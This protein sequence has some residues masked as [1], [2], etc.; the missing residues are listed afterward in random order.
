M[1]NLTLLCVAVVAVVAIASFAQANTSGPFTTS[2]PIGYTLTDWSSSLSFPKFNSALGTLTEVDLTFNAG[3]ETTLTVT[4]S[5]D[6][7]S[8][9][10]AN[11]NVQL[12]VE[13]PGSYFSPPQVNFLSPAYYYTLA[14]GGSTTSGLLTSTGSGTEDDTLPA[15]LAEFNGPGTIGLPASTFTQ[16]YVANTGGN[17]AAGQVTDAELTGTVTYQ[18][19]P[20][21]TPEPSTLLLLGMGAIGLLG[22]GWRKRRMA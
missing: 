21:P 4:N 3:L 13:D 17:T 7:G 12:S 5:S 2:T 15:I 16:T 22:Y 10:S 6:S 19:N 9:G 18:Y 14:G 1:R 8:S 20:V 11:T